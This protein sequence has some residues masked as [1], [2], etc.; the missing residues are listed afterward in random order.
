MKSLKKTMTMRWFWLGAVLALA[1][2]GWA[3]FRYAAT[4]RVAVKKTVY[5]CPMHHQ[6]RRDH[7]G[8][9]PICSMTLI[10]LE[11]EEKGNAMEGMED[12]GL[13]GLAPVKLSDHKQQM[14]GVR[15]AKAGIES[16]TRT[17][18]TVGRFAGG[19]GDFAALAGDFAAQNSLKS[20]G[21]YVVADVYAL[22]LP[23][24]KVGQKAFV[25]PLSGSGARVEGR[26]SFLYPYDG[27]QSRV[28]RVRVSLPKSDIRDI[29]ANVEIEA[30]TSPKLA[31]PPG[32]VMDTGTR[33]YVFLRTEPGTFVP[34]EVTIG[35]EGDEGW[36]VLAGLQEGDEVVDGANFLIDADSQIKAAFEKG[37]A[38]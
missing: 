7:P 15:M 19:G 3:I 2:G 5:T 33:R 22:D 25:S 8:S 11:D 14:I 16:L 32:A 26:V 6:I 13:P 35:Y 30:S 17:I 29:F 20:S 36:E 28:T 37:D 1:G 24:V 18:R 9:C 38:P 31:V 10:P 23:F 12:K 21:R 4:P 34:R 27:T